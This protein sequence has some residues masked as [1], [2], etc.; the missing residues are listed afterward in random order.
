MEEASPPVCVA[1]VAAVAA[2]ARFCSLCGTPVVD[3][4]SAPSTRTQS[5]ER[6]VV[7][8]LFCDLPHT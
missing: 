3:E 6:K 5:E 2:D 1:C 8:A 7:T 4:A